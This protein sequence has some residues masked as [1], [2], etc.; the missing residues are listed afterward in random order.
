MSVTLDTSTYKLTSNTQKQSNYNTK[1]LQFGDG[2]INIALDGINYDRE[3]WSMDF[4]PMDSTEANT[5]EAMLKNSVSG[6]AYYLKWM[7]AGEASY[8]YWIAESVNKAPVQGS[9]TLWKITCTLTRMFP[10]S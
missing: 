8:K 2:Y 10:L 3:Q 6:E 4:I 9:S 1:K 5:L 7:P